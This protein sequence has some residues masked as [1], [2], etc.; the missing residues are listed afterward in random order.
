ME[1]AFRTLKLRTSPGNK[2]PWFKD[3]PVAQL[4]NVAQPH[5]T[6]IYWPDLDVDLSVESMEF[7]ERVPLVSLTRPHNAVRSN[8]ARRRL[9]TVKRPR[10][11]RP[12]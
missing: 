1:K 6:R 4:L 9:K 10:G 5:P 3:V 11:T 8:R 12:T 2:F 7:P